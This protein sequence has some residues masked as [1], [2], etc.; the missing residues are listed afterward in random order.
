VTRRRRTDH[1][2][3]EI[4]NGLRKLGYTVFDSSR[5]GYGFP[6]LLV[7]RGD[8]LFLLEVKTGRE[9]L[10][11]SEDVFAAHFPVSV[12]HD[13]DEATQAVAWQPT[14]QRP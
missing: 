11:P 5:F 1:N 6:D 2:H 7:L 10:T 14:Q 4:R 8:A 13:L 3:S 12:V 9:A